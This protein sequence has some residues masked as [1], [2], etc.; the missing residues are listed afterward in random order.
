MVNNSKR[1]H[2]E[3]I[4][5]RRK[6]K[7]YKRSCILFLLLF[8]I[9]VTLCL[10]LKYFNISNIVVS[11]N[12]NITSNDIIKLSGIN[13]GNNVFYINSH[14]SK[15]GV[16][17]NPYILDVEISRKLPSTINISVTERK[18][19]FYGIK[20]EK[21][22]VFGG[23]GIV[24]EERSSVEGMKLVKLDGFD[25]NKSS[26]GNVLR[27]D[28]KRKVN[29]LGKLTSIL[30]SS[31]NNLGIDYIDINDLV[32]IKAYCGNMCFK[33]GSGDSLDK[34]INTAINILNGNNLKDAK[35]YIDVSFNGNPVFYVDK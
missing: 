18:A 33:L 21:F 1:E 30:F 35:G 6:K 22:L 28:D 26:L 15:E 9:L 4:V 20:N 5:R 27:C 23:D 16:L 8:S 34:K 7:L 3:L 17:S 2:N 11:G 32:N 10:K 31:S 24:L 25:Y 13:M 12:K 19:V 29:I 14:K